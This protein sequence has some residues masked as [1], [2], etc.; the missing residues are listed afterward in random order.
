MSLEKILLASSPG[1]QKGGQIS[2]A[3]SAANGPAHRHLN[4][5]YLTFYGSVVNYIS[6]WVYN[7]RTNRWQRPI[8]K[9]CGHYSSLGRPAPIPA[10]WP[11]CSCS[12]GAVL[13][14]F[15]RRPHTPDSSHIG[16]QVG[17]RI[18]PQNRSVSQWEA[19]EDQG[20]LL[21]ILCC[22]YDLFLKRYKIPQ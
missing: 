9:W 6:F 21:S 10:N 13:W 22:N 1:C 2:N 16:G 5:P 11:S 18:D 7:W 12:A 19:S 3:N 20:K 4:H 15:A 17:M 14:R 8:L